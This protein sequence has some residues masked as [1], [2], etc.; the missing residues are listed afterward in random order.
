[1]KKPY[2]L[3]GTDYINTGLTLAG[4]SGGYIDKT[5]TDNTYGTVPYN[6]SGSATTYEADGLWFNTNAGTYVALVGGNW[7]DAALCGCFTLT[8]GS[9]ASNADTTIGARL[10][11]GQ[12]AA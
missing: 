9:A 8:L 1:M 3:T 10:S 4:T 12:P 5:K 2:N 11:C 6:A 7:T